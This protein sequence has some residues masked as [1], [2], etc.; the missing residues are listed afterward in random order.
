MI[1]IWLWFSFIGQP[2]YGSPEWTGNYFTANT[3]HNLETLFLLHL[4]IRIT[5][6]TICL[7]LF[8]SLSSSLFSFII[9]F[10]CVLFLFFNT[11]LFKDTFEFSVDLV[12]S[13]V[14]SYNTLAIFL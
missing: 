9:L 4:S 10:L 7:N 11:E 14:C 13:H 8:P 2:I 3:G 1:Y 5:N 12:F 6:I